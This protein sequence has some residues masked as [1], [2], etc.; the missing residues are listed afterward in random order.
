MILHSSLFSA[1]D[2]P[3]T[4]FHTVV[5]R[6]ATTPL[7]DDQPLDYLASEDLL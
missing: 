4:G 1:F 5:V 3:S 6:T 7:A 2:P